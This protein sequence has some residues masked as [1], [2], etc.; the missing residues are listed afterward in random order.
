MVQKA[1]RNDTAATLQAKSKALKEKQRSRLDSR[2]SYLID[3]VAERLQ[4]ES[5]IVEEFVLDGDQVAIS[6]VI[7]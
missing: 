2:H 4:L 5:N 1:A 3:I 6:P 7:T